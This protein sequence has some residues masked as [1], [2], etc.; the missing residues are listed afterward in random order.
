L[1][2]GTCPPAIPGCAGDNPTPHKTTI[3]DT[4][5]HFTAS[6]PA[7]YDVP[8]LYRLGNALGEVGS[9]LSSAWNDI[10]YANT[11][12]DMNTPRNDRYWGELSSE[13][14]A[15]VL[16]TVG[17]LAARSAQDVNSKTAGLMDALSE[18]GGGGPEEGEDTPIVASAAKAPVAV[19]FAP[20]E[21]E[22]MADT[23]RNPVPASAPGVGPYLYRGVHHNHPDMPNALKG[24]AQPWGGHNDPIE[25]Q[26]GN[27]R[28]NHTSWTTDPYVARSWSRNGKM[29]GYGDGPGVVLRIPAPV[30]VSV[31]FQYHA[32]EAE[33]T[34]PGTIQGADVSIDGGDFFTP[35]R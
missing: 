19:H 28:S 17:E 30:G 8:L 10:S 11:G 14:K 3:S 18:F 1:A 7:S 4:Q 35:S 5:T 25:H 2:Q 22:A 32:H 16:V 34:L 27:N 6:A 13:E 15:D 24:I 12:V 21:D 31:G 9:A 33:I 23:V 29:L 26:R 20:V